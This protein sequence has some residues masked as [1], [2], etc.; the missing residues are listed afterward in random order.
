MLL[1]EYLAQNN[2]RF[3]S[4]PFCKWCP[5]FLQWDNP[6][7]Y[8][9]LSTSPQPVTLD[10]SKGWLFP[11]APRGASRSCWESTDAF[12]WAK[13]W[14]KGPPPNSPVFTANSTATCCQ[15]VH[16]A[17]RPP[18]KVLP[19]LPCWR[20]I[21]LLCWRQPDLPRF[22]WE[23][24]PNFYKIG[25][26]HNFTWACKSDCYSPWEPERSCPLENKTVSGWI[27]VLDGGHGVLEMGSLL[28]MPIVSTQKENGSSSQLLEKSVAEA[29]RVWRTQSKFDVQFLV[30]LCFP[31]VKYLCLL[32][33]EF[34]SITASLAQ[35]PKHYRYCHYHFA[36][37]RQ[38]WAERSVL[39]KFVVLTEIIVVTDNM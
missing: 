31:T 30:R 14:K 22:K 21:A 37:R 20:V 3:F 26:H 15:S 2:L 39:N 12:G 7:L 16:P 4:F 35:R 13:S 38:S 11:L 17:C 10:D 25:K 34:F 19:R 29:F 8:I 6:T 36:V 28:F 18:P 5:R 24:E 9:S 32:E 1:C 27:Q 23:A 33:K